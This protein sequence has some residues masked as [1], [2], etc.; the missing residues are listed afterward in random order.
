MKKVLFLYCGGTIGQVPTKQDDG[1]VALAPPKDDTQFREVCEPIIAGFS[2]RHDVE[3]SF[4][5]VTAKDST[6]MTPNDWRQIIMRVKKAQ[7]QEKYD[8]VGIA[9]G[10]DTLAYIA[11][12]LGLALH[13]KD[14]QKTGLRIPV[15]VTGA[16]NP[17]YEQGGDGRFNLENLFRVTAAAM[18][19]GI[20]DVMVNFWDRVMLGVRCKKM[21][22]KDFAAFD[23]PCFPH[24]GK[25]DAGGVHLNP[26]LVRL[27]QDATEPEIALAAKFG[28][29]VVGFE[30]SP[31]LD[32]SIVNNLVTG[33]TVQAM[34]LKSLGEGNVPCEGPGSMLPSITMATETYDLPMLI[35]TK[36]DAGSAVASH[37]EAGALA[38]K[39][40]GIPCLDHTD[41]ATDVKARWLLGNGVANTVAEFKD[42]MFTSYCGEVTEPEPEEEDSESDS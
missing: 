16:Q 40:G 37:Y 11:V 15:V 38:V 6:N 31:G 7:D 36:F 4:E 20:G 8:A 23:S 18:K 21:H 27:S 22:E 12:A 42:A 9:H 3:V 41:V 35:T 30:L 19:A 28:T 5:F 33:G 17:V 13:G 39:A 26:D 24:V 29:N 32:P 25:I 2:E 10:T 1:K 34:I 14:P